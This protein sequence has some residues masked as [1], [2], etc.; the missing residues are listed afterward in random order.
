MTLHWT[1]QRQ[2]RPPRIE[3]SGDTLI[4]DGTAYEF[5]PQYVEYDSPHKY[6]QRAQR[7]G[8][9]ELH[10]LLIGEEREVPV[11]EWTGETVPVAGRTQAE[12]DQREA[13]ELA[14]REQNEALQT[15]RERQATLARL[16][17]AL[18]TVIW[19]RLTVEER[20]QIREALPDA[21]EQVIRNAL[22]KL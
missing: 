15:L 10:V 14:E 17:L 16:T 4:I 19:P 1:P 3:Q 21:D 22:S 6:V 13:D 5:A 9:G 2:N 8:A 20:T 11:V 7:G 18:T 12:V